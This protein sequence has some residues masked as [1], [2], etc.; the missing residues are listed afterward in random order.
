MAEPLKNLYS[1]VYVDSL[2]DSLSQVD[3]SIDK[4]GFKKTVFNTD[5]EQYELKQRMRRLAVVLNQ[6]L[7]NDYKKDIDLIVRW[8]HLLKAQSKTGQSFEYLFLAEYVDMFG[9]QDV[10]VSLKAIEEITQFTSCEFAIRSF[11]I[12]EPKK[13]MAYMLRWSKHKH[14]NVRRFSSEGCRPR[15]PWGTAIKAFKKDPSMVLPILE[16]L[17]ND[18][19]LYVRKSVA[20]NLNDIAKDNPQ[21]VIELIQKWKG[22][23]AHTD[24]ILK[25]GSR[26]LLK[27]ANAEVLALFDLNTTL[28]CNVVEFSLVKTKIKLGDTLQ[29]SFTLN[30]ILKKSTKLRI[31]FAVYYVK[32][33]GKSSRKLFKITENT[34]EK[35]QQVSY[36]KNLSFKDLTTRKHYAGNHKISLVVNGNELAEL[37]FM[38]L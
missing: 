7:F 23:S 4:K 32:S 14:V 26:T 38:L 9:Q 8:V 2:L 28:T 15:L 29:F 3:P 31:E 33:T 13:V 35:G 30:P 12:N 17:K 16:N 34:F 6:Y 25:H 21:L 11:I 20:N 5:W 19:E 1:K 24:W 10:D 36:T 18:S 27:K 37:D 22:T